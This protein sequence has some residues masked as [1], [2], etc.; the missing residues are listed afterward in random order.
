VRLIVKILRYVKLLVKLRFQY[1]RM[2]WKMFLCW[3]HN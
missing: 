2:Q 3:C 1:C